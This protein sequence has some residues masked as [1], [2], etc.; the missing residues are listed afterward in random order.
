[1]LGFLFVYLLDF[2]FVYSR[3]QSSDK[4]VANK[5]FLH[6]HSPLQLINSFFSVQIFLI[7]LYK[8]K[9]FIV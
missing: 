4:Y 6:F 7:L 8:I 3:H 5:G 2:I 9:V 1:M